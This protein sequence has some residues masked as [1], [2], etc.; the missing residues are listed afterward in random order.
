MIEHKDISYPVYLKLRKMIL[1]G[2]LKPGE[3]LLQEKL[4]RDLGVSR[5]P[6]LKALQ[7]LEYDFLVE[8][9]PRRGMIVKMLTHKEMID[10]YYVREGIESIAIR[11]TTE[12][13]T[14]SQLK[15]LQ[16]LWEPF[17]GK[18]NIDHNKYR[19]ADE[20]FHSLILE[21]SQNQILQK[22]YSKNLVE[23]R[24]VQMGLQRPPEETL[25]EH[26]EMVDMISER[27]TDDA[28]NLMKLH[29]RR[30]RQKI[31]EDALTKKEV[32]LTS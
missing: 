18:S 29:I 10:I 24:V 5:T 26:L 11:L 14:Q 2:V 8:S 22:T 3:K 32:S 30:S 9:I 16:S 6:L 23:A 27:N 21:F 4:A 31:I 17:V 20:K 1:Q 28:E 19:K 25:G 15:Q 13:I 12:L 7:I